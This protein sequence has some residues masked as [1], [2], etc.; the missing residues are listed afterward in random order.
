MA[1]RITDINRFFILFIFDAKDIKVLGEKLNA[2][3][4][5]KGLFAIF[6]NTII[7]CD[8]TDGKALAEMAK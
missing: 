5:Y 6:D 2:I 7:E 3:K 4:R 8:G 1:S